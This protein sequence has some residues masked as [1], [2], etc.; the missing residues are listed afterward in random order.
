MSMS[1]SSTQKGLVFHNEHVSSL[2]GF[3]QIDNAWDFV[4][5]FCVAALALSIFGLLCSFMLWF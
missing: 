5:K 1:T 4:L 3:M 2:L